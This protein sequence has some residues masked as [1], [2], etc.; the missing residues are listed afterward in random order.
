MPSA[1]LLA[2]GM[3]CI[4]R[5]EKIKDESGSQPGSNPEPQGWEA[6]MLITGLPSPP[7]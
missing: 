4:L 1:F 2:K 5:K 3:L 6:S 7:L